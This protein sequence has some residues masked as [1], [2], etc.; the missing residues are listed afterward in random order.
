MKSPILL[1]AIVT[2]LFG[3]GPVK[4]TKVPA[5]DKALIFEVTLPATLDA[6]WAAFT[7]SEGL[8]TWLTPG[9]VVD[10]REGGEWTAH[11]PGGGTGGGT[12]LSFA[13]KKKL[14]M[15]AMAPETFPHVR[16][17]RTTATWEFAAMDA[18]TT[19]LTLKQTGW[20]EGAEWDKAYDYLAAG[21]AQL[22]NTLLRRFEKGPIDW[23]KEWG[24][25]AKQ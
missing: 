16:A 4:V 8:S 7:T 1:F 12:I 24:Q 6:V 19:R 9:A 23:A 11:F 17:E 20:K 2:S 22:F 13:P 25:P 15:S 14:V 5:P 10:L 3:Q 18:G 21:N